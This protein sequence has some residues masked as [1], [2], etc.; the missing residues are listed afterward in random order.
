MGGILTFSAL[1]LT[2]MMLLKVSRLCVCGAIDFSLTVA[3]WSK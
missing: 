1:L 3:F 2:M